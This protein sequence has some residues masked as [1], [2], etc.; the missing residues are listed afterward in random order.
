VN[1][2]AASDGP[3]VEGHRFMYGD[4]GAHVATASILF[5]DRL[6]RPGLGSSQRLFKFVR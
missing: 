5:R 2:T 4:I 1:Y 3:Y 6:L